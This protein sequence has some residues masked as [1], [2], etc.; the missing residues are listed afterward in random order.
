MFMTKKKNVIWMFLLALV[1]GTGLVA[2]SDDDD[3]KGGATEVYVEEPGTLSK[4]LGDDRFGIER[5]TVSG[6]LDYEDQYLIGELAVDGALSELDLTDATL[7]E[8]TIEGEMFYGSG[9]V[10]IKLPKTL[11]TVGEMAFSQS[12]FL[13]EIVFPAS[14]KT[15][16]YQAFEDC[17]A[18]TTVTI[19]GEP[20]IDRDV[21]AGCSGLT[22][23]RLNSTTGVNLRANCGIYDYAENITVYLP[24]GMLDG[25]KYRYGDDWGQEFKE[26]IEAPDTDEE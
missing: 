16:M 7:D 21:F 22:T 5:L 15:V 9:L 2:C 19:E 17:V 13:K 14:V 10:T 8:N 4:L 23:L 3:D 25:Y 1:T 6:T 24:A 18:L 12:K 20:S 11:E 26:I